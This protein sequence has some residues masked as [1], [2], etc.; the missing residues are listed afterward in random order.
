M[1]R[2]VLMAD[3]TGGWVWGRLRLF[4]MDFVKVALGSRGMTV[5]D[6]QQCTK[7]AEEWSALV[8]MLMIVFNA[9]TFAWPCVLL[10]CPP[11]RW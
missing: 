9:A 6:V 11:T 7:D 3:V 8:H 5:E 4:L 1:A 2:W 10:D